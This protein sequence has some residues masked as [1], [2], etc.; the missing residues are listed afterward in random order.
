MYPDYIGRQYPSCWEF[1]RDY[2]RD[3]IG[4]E[5]PEHAYLATMFS[6]VTEPETGDLALI[7][8]AAHCGIYADGNI[9]HHTQQ[10]GVI[11]DRAD[12]FPATACYRL[13]IGRNP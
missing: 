2:Y 3:T 8:G 11:S 6:P 4:V 7:A 12:T 13:G 9:L 1:V 5:V 10:L